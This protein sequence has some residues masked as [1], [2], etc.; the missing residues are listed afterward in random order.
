M[1]IRDSPDG[2]CNTPGLGEGLSLLEGNHRQGAN[3]GPGGQ[4][5][6]ALTRSRRGLSRLHQQGLPSNRP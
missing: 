1:C 5:G 2:G 3:P 4:G 6:R